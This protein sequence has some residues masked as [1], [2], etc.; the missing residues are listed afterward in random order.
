MIRNPARTAGELA[1]LAVAKRYSGVR[2]LTRLATNSTPE[3]EL[4]YIR[5]G[6]PSRLPPVVI[7]PGGPGLSSVLPY[8]RLRRLASQV[9]LDLIMIEH[10]GVGLSRRDHSGK[11]LPTSAMR[12]RSVIEDIVAVLDQEHVMRATIVGSSY[13]S[14]I[15]SSFGAAHPDRVSAMLLDSALQSSD[16]L[17]TERKAVRETLWNRDCTSTQLTRQLASKGVEQ[18]VLLDV[19]R[20]AF[21]LDGDRLLEPLL[22]MRLK[23]PR[24]LAWKMLEA[25]STRDASIS[26]IPGVYEFDLVGV[27]G[28]R[29]LG[30][31]AP[32]DGLP[33][34]PALT[35]SQ[36]ADRFPPFAG[37]P[38]D[39]LSS[40][41][42]FHWPLLLL[43]GS[44][45]LRTPSEIASAMA[46]A[47]PNA[48]LAMIENGHSALDTHPLALLNALRW[49]AIGK[50]HQVPTITHKLNNLPKRGVAARF[51]QLLQLLLRD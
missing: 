32:L 31:G 35:Y 7:I 14:Y 13:G 17:E 9:G 36:L 51:P 24:S 22:R 21:E 41:K 48:A 20:A 49:L 44:R 16:H 19:A 2:S 4:T 37:E 3:F 29:E 18:R 38:F 23:N 6:Q 45:D 30:Y 40:A 50:H 1:M 10:R 42:E 43:S 11:E 8:G 39:L 34:D 26:R 47:A 15:A 5:T 27:I 33:L 25:Y 28:F 46:H 12:V